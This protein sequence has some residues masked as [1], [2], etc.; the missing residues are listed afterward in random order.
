M[1][2][3]VGRTSHHVFGGDNQEQNLQLHSDSHKHLIFNVGEVEYGIPLSD[4]KEVISMGPVTHVPK[5]PDYFEG[6]LNLRGE[7]ISIIDLRRKLGLPC[8]PWQQQKTCIIIFEVNKL[9]L[10]VIVDNVIEVQGFG[11][12]QMRQELDISK[13]PEREFIQGVAT[14]HSGEMVMLLNSRKL[15][16]PLEL[17]LIT[18]QLQ[19]LSPSHQSVNS[20]AAHVR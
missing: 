12:Q 3:S 15:L 1:N 2:R 10:G 14:K 7:V 6:I 5:L 9:T 13:H 8:K 18:Q 16:N 11:S 20:E 19:Q 17:G 4:V